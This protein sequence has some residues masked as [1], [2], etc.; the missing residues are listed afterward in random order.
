V[1]D[2]L[3]SEGQLITTS[4]IERISLL[5]HQHIHLYGHCPFNSAA[6]IGLR[7]LRIATSPVAKAMRTP[8]R[9]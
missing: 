3:R 1:L 5:P 2:Q 7:T 4:K 6:P 9:V 8:N